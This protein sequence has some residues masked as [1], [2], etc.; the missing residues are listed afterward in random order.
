VVGSAAEMFDPEN[1]DAIAAAIERVVCSSERT[2]LLRARGA[3][4]LRWFSWDRAAAETHAIYRSL[5]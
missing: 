3:E 4:R 2:D 5:L 1:P